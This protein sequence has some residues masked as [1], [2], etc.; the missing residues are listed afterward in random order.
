MVLPDLF[1]LNNVFVTSDIIQNLLSVHC[2][3]TNN[4]RS[5][6][7]DLFGLSVKDLSTWNM[8]A[9]CDTS[10]P[11]YTMRLPSHSTPSS[12]VAAPTTLVVSASTWHRRLGHPSVDTMSNASSIIYSRRTHDL[13]HTCQLGHHTCMPFVSSASRADNNFDLIH[14]DLWTSPIVSISGYK[15]YLIIL[16]DRSYFV[17]TFSLCVKYDTFPTLSIFSP[18]FTRSLAAP[19]KSSSV[20]TTVSSTMLPPAHSFPPMGSSCRCPAHTPLCI[21]VNPSALFTPSII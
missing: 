17:W 19:S 5:M 2:F 3:T 15:Y 14:C 21:T 10:G 6:E 7:F 12:S 8:I 18:L 1:Y 16:D 13:C 4:W 9:R 11:L 20:T